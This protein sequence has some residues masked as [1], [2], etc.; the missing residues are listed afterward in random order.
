MICDFVL[1]LVPQNSCK[2][3]HVRAWQLSP[4]AAEACGRQAA[5]N[6]WGTWQYVWIPPETVAAGAKRVSQIGVSIK[7]KR[8]T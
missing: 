1:S 5:D 3:T 6:S 7:D 8:E 2:H 4:M